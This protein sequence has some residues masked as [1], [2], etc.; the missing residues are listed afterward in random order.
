MDNYERSS[1]GGKANGLLS[2]K[3][4]LE[5]YYSDPN[6]CLNCGKIIEV[7]EN[8]QVAMVRCKKFCNHICAATYNNKSRP[9]KNKPLK[10]IICRQCN[11]VFESH[12]RT[13]ICLKCSDLNAFENKS[14]GDVFRLYKNWQSARSSIV[15]HAKRT[16]KQSD[17]LKKCIK[18]GYD[19]HY[20]I[21][22]IKDVKDFSK[23]SLIKE[24]NH[25]DNLIALCP[26]HH[27]EFDHIV[28]GDLSEW[29]KE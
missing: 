16:Y 23:D 28:D 14:K 15:G 1:L 21:S 12:D 27:W 25:I 19:K 10:K 5:G 8:V 29:L 20:E 7:P 17:K 13:K 24:I 26:N 11:N 9:K 3:K 6:K 4:A 2:R 18:C 22:H